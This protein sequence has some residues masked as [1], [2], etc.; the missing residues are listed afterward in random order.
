MT[1]AALTAALA[2][3]FAAGYG[4]LTLV[5]REPVRLGIARQHVIARATG[6]RPGSAPRPQTP[7][8]DLPGATGTAQYPSDGMDLLPGE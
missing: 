2:T 5:A 1:F 8:D 4:T 3:I 6:R 7:P